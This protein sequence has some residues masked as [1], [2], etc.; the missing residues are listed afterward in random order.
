[1]RDLEAPLESVLWDEDEEEVEAS[2]RL[3]IM[4]QVP[5]RTEMDLTSEGD[6]D[7]DGDVE[8]TAG[9]AAPKPRLT[10]AITS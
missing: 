3:P 4:S 10:R 7:P 8:R 9:L 2:G 5:A 1:M 6:D